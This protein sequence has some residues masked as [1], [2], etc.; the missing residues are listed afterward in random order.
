MP[1]SRVFVATCSAAAPK[2]KIRAPSHPTGAGE[3]RWMLPKGF[4]K[5]RVPADNP[6]SDAKVKLGRYLFYDERMSGNGTQSCSSCHQQ[7]LAFTDGQP[8]GNRLDRRS[9]LPRRDEPGEHRLQFRC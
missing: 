4:P 5:P 3:Y 7:G 1:Y 2:G 9:A 8:Q 6:M